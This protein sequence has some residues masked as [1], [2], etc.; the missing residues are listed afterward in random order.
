MYFMQNLLLY[1]G[2]LRKM[3][4]SL[5]LKNGVSS[6]YSLIGIVYTCCL[7]IP[8]LAIEIVVVPYLYKYP[9]DVNFEVFMVN[10]LS[11]KFSSSKFYWQNFLLYHLGSRIHLNGNLLHLQGTMAYVHLYSYRSSFENS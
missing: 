7:A 3:L 1:I 9:R 5:Y 4:A 11:A 8:T 2:V 6:L 10:W